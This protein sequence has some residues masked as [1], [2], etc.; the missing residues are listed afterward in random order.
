M[1]HSIAKLFKAPTR[2]NSI[3]N[4][5]GAFALRQAVPFSDAL[6]SVKSS[7][8]IEAK[9]AQ[10]GVGLH[11]TWICEAGMCRI[12]SH[13]SR[14]NIC[15]EVC[16]DFQEIVETHLSVPTAHPKRITAKKIRP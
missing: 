2:R 13:G 10:P 6:L 3:F 7:A 1:S 16:L 12:G 9:L 4:M 8:E 11:C 5:A 14:A 15:S